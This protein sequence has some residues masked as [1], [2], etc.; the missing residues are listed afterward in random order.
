MRRLIIIRRDREIYL[1]LQNNVTFHGYEN[2]EMM[3]M[4]SRDFCDIPEDLPENGL[5]CRVCREVGK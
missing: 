4:D 2:I 3:K 5:I 1:N